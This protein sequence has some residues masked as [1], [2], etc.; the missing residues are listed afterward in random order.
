[1]EVLI[2]VGR[3]ALQDLVS[4]EMHLVFAKDEIEEDIGEWKV[5]LCYEGR[6]FESSQSSW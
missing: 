6:C 1:M 2:P 3:L 5:E 4:E